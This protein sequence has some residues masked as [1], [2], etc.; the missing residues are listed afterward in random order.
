MVYI[1]STALFTL[2][3]MVTYTVETN[4]NDLLDKFDYSWGFAFGWTAFTLAVI[5]ALIAILFGAPKLPR[6][7]IEYRE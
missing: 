7:I 4:M 5:A 6:V 3:A 1:F 2:V